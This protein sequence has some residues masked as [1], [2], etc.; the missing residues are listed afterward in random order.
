VASTDEIFRVLEQNKC[1]NARIDFKK[2]L[3]LTVANRHVA[4][5][6]KDIVVNLEDI[7]LPEDLPALLHSINEIF[8]SNS[9]SL[10]AH[11]RLIPDG[12]WHLFCY[13][14]YKDKGLRKP[15]YLFGNIIDVSEYLEDIE[16]DPVLLELKEKNSNK[17]TGRMDFSEIFGKEYLCKI[18]EPLSVED[19][20]YTAIFGEDGNFICS[21]DPSQTGFDIKKYKYVKRVDVKISHSVSANW[22]IAAD[23]F[24]IIEEYS[25][26][27]DVLTDTL[28]KMANAFVLL[29]NEMANSERTNKQLSENVEQHILL[30]SVYNTVLNEKNSMETLRS[31][32]RQT[33]EF[34]KLDRVVVYEDFPETGKYRLRYEWVPDEADYIGLEEFA[35][36][37]YP[38]LTQELADYETYFSN[39]T[40]HV[41]L[42]HTFSSYVA[43]NLT[44]DGVKYGIIIYE[45]ITPEH[46]LTH[47]EKRL[48]R[49][50]SQI[51]ATVLMRCKDNEKLDETNEQLR[52]LAF[53]DP[54]LRVKNKTALNGDLSQE[55]ES[56]TPGVLLAFKITN[57][58][59]LNHLMGHGFTNEL[60][61]KVLRYVAEMDGYGAEPYR[62]SDNVF[63][64]LLRNT[65]AARAKD[66]CEELTARFRQPWEHDGSEHFFE[67]GTGAAPY[68]ETG[69]AIEEIY[70]AATMSVYK[71]I[72]YG[73]NTYAFFARE[74]EL[75]A[76]NDYKR[77]QTLRNAVEN[78][79]EGITVRFQPVFG[80]DGH[81]ALGCETLI[82]ISDENSPP[83]R[84]ILLA[85]S[86]GLDIAI[87]SWVLKQACEFCKKMRKEYDPDFFVSV[88]TT[89][90][91][92]TTRAII[93]MVEKALIESGLQPDALAIE[94]E[95]QTIVA[96]YETV[97]SV[98]GALK[99]LGVSIIVD[100]L[101]SHYAVPTLMKHSCI[102]YVKADIT[103]FT[104]VYED[105]FE[106]MVTGSL[107]K[108]ARDYGVSVCVKKIETEEQ[109]EYI[110]GVDLHQGYF[111]AKPMDDEAFTEFVREYSDVKA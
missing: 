59:N 26:T 39:N 108:R 7:V 14:L 98:L 69:T 87:D 44:G 36:A 60:I 72:E 83:A 65:D 17:F 38:K 71:A 31:V 58:K 12:K 45:V 107:L 74:F 99:K 13:G 80:S 42:D 2:D 68:P 77:A 109:L 23:A 6:K 16:N 21:A 93:S 67:I 73:A 18:Q 28:S 19:K 15:T 29:Y 90:R 66:F 55:L 103:L 54:V 20:L 110:E 1:V 10:F 62:F 91:E 75:P 11:C 30:N 84:L 63:I 97:S 111:Y 34:M 64:V 33:G 104:T 78:G 105:D 52:F 9:G 4:G 8:A 41:V 50:I 56:G 106:R 94:I 102:N 101:G 43:S 70:R 100:N 89:K 24:E 53:H 57:I 96:H 49:S 27:H 46:V 86:M 76:E 3:P 81:H 79:M 82:A 25:A 37:D 95:E 47:S 22:V 85:E 32:V 5:D 40:A 35:Y 48:L 51:I 61:I 92:L 88:N